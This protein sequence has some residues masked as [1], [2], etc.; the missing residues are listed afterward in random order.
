MT[1]TL[2]LSLLDLPAEV[3]LRIY[4]FLI[5]QGHRFCINRKWGALV[6]EKESQS[7]PR[8]KPLNGVSVALFRVHSTCYHEAVAL[9]YSHN[10]FSFRVGKDA[11]LWFKVIGRRNAGL[12]RYLHLHFQTYL[13]LRPSFFSSHSFKEDTKSFSKIISQLSSI[14]SLT[15]DDIGP[16]FSNSGWTIPH[17]S[18]VK[19]VEKQL[20][21]LTRFSH[22]AVDAEERFLRF[23]TEDAERRVDVSASQV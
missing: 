23:A 15:F 22:Y 12:I 2:P 19:R 8:I 7:D 11:A 18:F 13:Y 17:L 3:R 5:P 16:H 20:P 4:H 9:L 10:I 21:W 6:F 1:R 14:R